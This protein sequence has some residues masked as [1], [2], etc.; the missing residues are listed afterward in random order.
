[1]G[2]LVKD[3]L[4]PDLLSGATLNAAGSTDGTVAT[5]NHPGL[6][7]IVLETDGSISST[8]NTATLDVVIKASDSS[9]FASGVVTLGQ[10]EMSGND[11]AQEN[12]ERIINVYCDKRYLRA[13]VTLGGTAPVYT[14]ATCKV[15]QPHWNRKSTTTA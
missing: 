14:G 10:I 7:A 3:S 1:M 15:R 4:E 12:Q 9:T 2:T 13:S 8:S 6:V 11:D 5:V